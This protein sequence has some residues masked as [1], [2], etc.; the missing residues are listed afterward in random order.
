M[1]GC[2]GEVLDY[3]PPVLVT[4]DRMHVLR[5]GDC[6]RDEGG[7]GAGGG[8]LLHVPESIKLDK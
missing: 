8:Q 2:E 6:F 7:Q 5:V 3:A 4:V 1:P